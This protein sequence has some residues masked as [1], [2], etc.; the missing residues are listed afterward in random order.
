MGITNYLKSK[1]KYL[2]SSQAIFTYVALLYLIMMFHQTKFEPGSVSGGGGGKEIK[3]ILILCGGTGT[4]GSKQAS[5][6]GRQIRQ[7]EVMLKSAAL[8]TKKKLHFHVI[9]DSK[10]LFTRLVNRTSSWPDSY[11]RKLRFSM[12]NVWYPEVRHS[13]K[14]S[15]RKSR[16]WVN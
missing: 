14:H 15:F 10:K 3:F 11:R 16:V 2:K 13:F 6:L 4:Q 1:T 5:D 7:A 8:F 9:A 12:H